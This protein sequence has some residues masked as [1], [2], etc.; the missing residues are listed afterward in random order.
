MNKANPASFVGGAALA[1]A[2]AVAAPAAAQVL[3]IGSDGRV[4]TYSGPTLFTAQGARPLLPAP[5]PR[6]AAGR[7]P[8]EVA[9]AIAESAGRHGVSAP[10]LTEMAWQESHFNSRAVSRKGALGVMQLLP[11]TAARLGVDPLDV[12]A[13]IDGGAAYIAQLIRRFNG[14][15]RLALA[16]YNAGPETVERYGGVPPFAETQSYVRA[17]L[18]RLTAPSGGAAHVE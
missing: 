13:N 15:L 8:A 18:A 9:Q 6:T 12:R 11:E 14:D 7:P 17:I 5:A 2:M 3:D 16:A 1:A 4:A 10:L